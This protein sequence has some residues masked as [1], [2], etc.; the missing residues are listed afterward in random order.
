[1]DQ[2]RIFTVAQMLFLASRDP[3]VE[4]GKCFDI[5]GLALQYGKCATVTRKECLAVMDMPFGKL[6]TG[7]DRGDEHRGKKTAK[8][9]TIQISDDQIR[10]LA[11][12]AKTAAEKKTGFFTCLSDP[13]ME[14]LRRYTK[15]ILSL[16]EPET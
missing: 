10:L 2:K 8:P 13:D 12:A 16:T 4:D 7:E 9:V 15:A 6:L 11:T 1:M 14:W 3:E 5:V